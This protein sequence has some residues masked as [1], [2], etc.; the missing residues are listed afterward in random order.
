VEIQTQQPAAASL[1]FVTLTGDKV[2]F[3][4]PERSGDYETDNAAGRRHAEALMRLIR[5]TDNPTIYGSVVRAMTLH[6]TYGA[7]EIGFCSRIGIEL[8]GLV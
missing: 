5:E 7:V 8:I 1:S 6:G 2:D 3:W 4:A